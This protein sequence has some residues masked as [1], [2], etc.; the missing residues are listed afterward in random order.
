MRRIEAL[1]R[2]AVASFA[3]MLLCGTGLAQTGTFPDRPIR[4]VVPYGP[5]GTVDPTA[6]TLAQRASEI[7]GQPVVVENKPGAAGSIGTDFV[8]RAPAD[9][10]TVLIHTNVVA[11][12]PPLKPNLTYNF[13]KDMT[14]LMTID[15]TPFVV[16]VH[17]SLPVK[18]MKEL[19]EYV[20]ARPGKLNYGASGVA[21]S[22]HLRG[23][24]FKLE[25]GTDIVFVPYV[26]GGATL[27]GLVTNEIQI[28]FDTLPG[29]IGMIQGDKIKL[30]AVGSPERWFLVPDTPTMKETGYG[31][32]VSQW[33]GAY[34]RAD[35]PPAIVDKLARALKEAAADPKVKEAYRKL[36]FETVADGPQETAK[37][38]RDETDMWKKT[39]E[40]AGIKVN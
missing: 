24:Q 27:R 7:L 32:L 14:P 8:V 1:C 13:L 22:G 29:S 33:I 28:A 10:Y 11:S 19:V 30:L 15:E 23:E 26:D 4:F 36:G 6:R 37:R 5:G 40:S 17:P 12:E 9:G 20:K 39:I 21:S 25:T 38:L 31:S 16:L 34:V 3:A 2:V 18:S 35:T